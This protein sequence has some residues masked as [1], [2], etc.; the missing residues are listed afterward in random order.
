VTEDDKKQPPPPPE[1]SRP[2]PVETEQRGLRQDD[3]EHVSR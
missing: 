2:D 1:P 3:L